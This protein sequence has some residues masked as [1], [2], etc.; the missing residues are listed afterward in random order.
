MYREAGQGSRP[1][2]EP[3]GGK[4]EALMGFDSES[5]A[6]YRATAMRVLASAAAVF[7]AASASPALAQ[8]ET[9]SA[10]AAAAPDA[11]DVRPQRQ[12]ALRRSDRAI[13]LQDIDAS[14]VSTPDKKANAERMITEE[15]ASLARATE[16]LQDARS[17]KDIVQ[18]NC[19][20]E[21]LTQIKGLLRLSERASVSMYQAIAKSV[22]D[23]INHEY[24]KIAVAHQKTQVLRS[25][26]EQCVGELSVYTGDTEVSVEIDD[27]IPTTDPTLPITPPP[28]PET[29]PVASGF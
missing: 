28:G 5:T 17:A 16:L 12:D 14:K 1:S 6:T 23:V 27:A 29:P 9:P 18:L 3:Q 10:P 24:T 4:G 21:K 20:N 7:L 26:A 2:S 13:R 25:E 8:D 19:V 11:T 22:Q 15:R